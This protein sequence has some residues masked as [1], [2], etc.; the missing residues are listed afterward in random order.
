GCAGIMQ[1]IDLTNTDPIDPVGVCTAVFDYV[2]TMGMKLTEGRVLQPW[3]VLDAPASDSASAHGTYR[4]VLATEATKKFF[5]LKL[6]E[7]TPALSVTTVAT[8]KDF[9]PASLHHPV[10][11]MMIMA[12]RDWDMGCLLVRAARGREKEAMS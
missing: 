3:Q 7:S 10:G 9:H 6:N 5:N 12:Q 8:I 2:H 11:R 4:N 1:V